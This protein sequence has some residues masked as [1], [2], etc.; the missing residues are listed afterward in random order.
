MAKLIPIIPGAYG[1]YSVSPARG[2]KENEH[3]S[4]TAHLLVEPGRLIRILPSLVCQLIDASY[5][6][7]KWLEF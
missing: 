6:S 4:C 1:R 5:S 3:V 7:Q 2:H